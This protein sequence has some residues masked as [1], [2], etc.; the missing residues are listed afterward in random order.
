MVNFYGPLSVCITEL[1]V[2]MMRPMT[3]YLNYKN[4]GEEKGKG[5]QA[6]LPQP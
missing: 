3:P 2:S 5:S 4:W 1:T 6:M